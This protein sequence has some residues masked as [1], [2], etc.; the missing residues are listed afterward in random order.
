ME[1]FRLSVNILYLGEHPSRME[2]FNLR[3]NGYKTRTL[4]RPKEEE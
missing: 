2:D 4:K 3:G 1:L